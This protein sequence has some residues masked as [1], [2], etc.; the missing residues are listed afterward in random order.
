M[1]FFSTMERIPTEGLDL[2]EFTQIIVNIFDKSLSD[3]LNDK[4]TEQE[5]KE[6]V[7]KEVQKKADKGSSQIPQIYSIKSIT[8]NKT[9]FEI[10][11]LIQ[12]ELGIVEDDATIWNKM[13]NS[14]SKFI[15]RSNLPL[16]SKSIYILKFA[17]F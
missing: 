7:R 11:E 5:S 15:I 8:K 13:I 12:N 4:Q 1:I 16:K 14:I 17:L 9:K 10:I 3:F 2:I 6:N